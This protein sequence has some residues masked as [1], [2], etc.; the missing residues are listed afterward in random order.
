MTVRGDKDK[1]IS[2][3]QAKIKDLE[4]QLSQLCNASTHIQ[5]QAKKIVDLEAAARRAQT[6]I[7]QG[8]SARDKDNNASKARITNL[9]YQLRVKTKEVEDQKVCNLLLFPLL[10]SYIEH[11]LLVIHG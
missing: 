7:S 6:I 3:E 1:E 5:D 2:R 4:T 9:E 8:Q 10:Y 11:V